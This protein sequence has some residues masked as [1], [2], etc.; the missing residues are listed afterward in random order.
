MNKGFILLEV[1]LA[2]LMTSFLS[3]AVLTVVN[4]IVRTQQFV[5]RVADVTQKAL[6]LQN[7]WEREIS[8]AF[9][10]EE[11]KQK[12]QTKDEKEPKPI[13]HVFFVET[14]DAGVLKTFSF[15]THSPLVSYWDKKI[16]K[17]K[18][19]ILRKLLWFFKIKR[20]IWFYRSYCFE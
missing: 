6:F 16:G 1:L 18:S 17:L 12:T 20:A 10:T 15:F 11:K 8:S 4:Q 7:E 14:T 3:V 2:L 19:R 5:E 9:A 13:D